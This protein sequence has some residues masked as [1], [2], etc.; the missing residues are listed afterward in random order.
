MPIKLDLLI[1]RTEASISTET[2]PKKLRQLQASLAAY[3]VAKADCEDGEDGDD[4]DDGKD[5]KDGE[6]GEDASRAEKAAAAAKKAA[7]V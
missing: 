5:G 7:E 2:D 3:S 6:D 4:G 1:R